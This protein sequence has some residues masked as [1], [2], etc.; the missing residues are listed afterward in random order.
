MYSE[1]ARTALMYVDYGGD[2]YA[3]MGIKAMKSFAR[4]RGMEPTWQRNERVEDFGTELHTQASSLFR[5]AAAVVWL[6][7]IFQSR[8][9]KRDKPEDVASTCPVSVK[10]HLQTHFVVFHVEERREKNYDPISG[11]PS[12]SIVF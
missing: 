1:H 11:R 8:R 7:S 4:P 2:A 6:L 12:N 10:T 3:G 9:G 5:T